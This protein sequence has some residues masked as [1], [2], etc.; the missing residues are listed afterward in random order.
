[1]AYTGSSLEGPE[2]LLGGR[3]PVH[4]YH[5]TGAG[6]DLGDHAGGHGG[7]DDVVAAVV[8]AGDAVEALHVDGVGS[9]DGWLQFGAAG[10]TLGHGSYLRVFDGVNRIVVKTGRALCAHPRTAP[11][12]GLLSNGMPWIPLESLSQKE[13]L[14]WGVRE[15]WED[16]QKEPS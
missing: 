1:M 2:A 15:G 11:G 13:V 9:A 3:S 8:L 14:V 4:G 7:P 16:W 6:L 5:R 12:R 10:N